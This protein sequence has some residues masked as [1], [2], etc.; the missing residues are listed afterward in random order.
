M[1]GTNNKYHINIENEISFLDNNVIWLELDADIKYPNYNKKSL[2]LF[3][4]SKSLSNPYILK[5]DK[6][7]C[8]F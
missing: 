6:K 2:K 7:E 1:Q 8:R 5:C 3:R 4:Y